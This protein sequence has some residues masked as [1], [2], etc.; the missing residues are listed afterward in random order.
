[1]PYLVIDTA[2]SSKGTKF[3]FCKF[4]GGIGSQ[5]LRLFTEFPEEAHIFKTFKEADDFCHKYNNS[6]MEE[7]V[8]NENEEILKE[9]L[10]E[11]RA[12][13]KRVTDGDLYDNR[14]ELTK[15]GYKAL[16]TLEGLDLFWVCDPLIKLVNKEEIKDE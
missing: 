8:N 15:E 2:L 13:I 14:G 6:L 3:Y 10:A 4:V 7:I 1:M 12:A 11:V 5:E 16:E 9:S